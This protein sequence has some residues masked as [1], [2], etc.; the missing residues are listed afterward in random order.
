MV[1]ADQVNSGASAGDWYLCYSEWDGTAFGVVQPVSGPFASYS[2]RGPS[3]LTLRYFA[4]DGTE[5]LAGGDA[6]DIARVDVVARGIGRAG[7]SGLTVSA[8]DSQSIA[9]R[10]RNR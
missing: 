7:L 2:R 3:G 6:R 1:G 4:T 5:V 8:I 10:V 9:V